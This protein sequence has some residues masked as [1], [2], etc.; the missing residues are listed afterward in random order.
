M[1]EVVSQPIEMDQLSIQAQSDPASIK[2]DKIDV[3][4][5]S[6]FEHDKLWDYFARLRQEDPVHYCED[7]AFGPF[8]SVTRYKDIMAVDTNHEDFSSEPAILL[9]DHPQTLSLSISSRRIRQNT[10]CIVQRLPALLRLAIWLS[11]SPLSELGRRIFW[12]ACRS[13]RR[14]TG[15]IGC[16][17]NSLH[18]CWRQS[19]TFL[20]KT[21]SCSLT[22]Q[23]WPLPPPR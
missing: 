23:T 14:L 15:L 13:V 12:I 7:S 1:S 3:S 16:R 22:G 11:L 18:K 17:L 4:D 6:L 19:S 21:E 9:G 10:I 20:L 8:W 5:P 2:L